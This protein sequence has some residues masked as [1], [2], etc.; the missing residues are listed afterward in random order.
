M[1]AI[2][3]VEIKC[4]GFQGTK[5]PWKS[6]FYSDHPTITQ[7]RKEATR[8]GWRTARTLNAS[9]NVFYADACSSCNPEEE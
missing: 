2:V 4:D 3:K 5:C 6:V 9:H 7:A 8:H 1:S